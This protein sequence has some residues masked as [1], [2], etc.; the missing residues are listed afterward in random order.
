VNWRTLLVGLSIGAAIVGLIALL[1][2]EVRAGDIVLCNLC[3]GYKL[4]KVGTDLLVECPG[5]VTP[6]LTVK[7]CPQPRAVTRGSPVGLY[8]TCDGSA[9]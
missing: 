6:W 8:V 7:N 5:Q 4:A 3:T 2:R 1:M 9:P